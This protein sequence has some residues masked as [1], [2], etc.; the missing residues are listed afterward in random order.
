MSRSNYSGDLNEWDL[1][2]W[3]GAD[4]VGLSRQDY[5][6][7]ILWEKIMRMAREGVFLEKTKKS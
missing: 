2:R 7:G 4:S 5:F 3:R 6:T 1:I